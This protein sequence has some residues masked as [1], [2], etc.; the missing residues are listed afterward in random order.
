MELTTF[1]T[2]VLSCCLKYKIVKLIQKFCIEAKAKIV[3]EI[4][5][6]SN[7]RCLMNLTIDVDI[8]TI[9]V[10]IYFVFFIFKCF[11]LNII[12]CGK[13]ENFCVSH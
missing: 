8:C 6:E 12:L 4:S 11:L 7:L 2:G 13:R 1:V 5:C 3:S 10:F 9:F